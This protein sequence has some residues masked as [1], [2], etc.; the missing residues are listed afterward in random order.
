MI[1]DI[2]PW[3]LNNGFRTD[4]PLPEDL[5][6]DIDE[7]GILTAEDALRFP[8]AGEWGGLRPRGREKLLYAFRLEQDGGKSLNLFLTPPGTSGSRVP[9]G[10]RRIPPSSLRNASPAHLAFAAFTGLHLFRWYASARF[11]GRCGT[12]AVPGTAERCMVCP[13]CGHVEYPRIAPCVIVAVMD[14][15]RLLLTRYARGLTSRHVLVAGFVE[16][17]ETAEQAAA[18]EVLEETGLHI[19]NI[20]YYGSQPWGL[21]GTLALGYLAD[22]DGADSIVTDTSELAEAVWVERSRIPACDGRASLTMKMISLFAQG[23]L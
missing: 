3:R 20:R 12:P 13:A 4:G 9:G 21:S 11:C 22:L 8:T 14:G 16:I 17:G 10:W 23:R 18:R 2:S 1:Q 5:V 15:E 6:M 19:R 7:G